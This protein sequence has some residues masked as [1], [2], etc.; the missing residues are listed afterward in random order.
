MRGRYN[1]TE[2]CKHNKLLI[3]PEDGRDCHCCGWHQKEIQRRK[4]LIREQ[5]LDVTPT[6]KRYLNLK[7]GDAE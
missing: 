1:T 3:C 5:G 7:K 6:F 2:S 4:T